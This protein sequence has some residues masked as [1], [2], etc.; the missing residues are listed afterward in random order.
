VKF[1]QQHEAVNYTDYILASNAIIPIGI[2]DG[3]RRYNICQ[4][5]EKPYPGKNRTKLRKDAEAEIQSFT[6]YLIS[7][8]AD[9]EVAQR[10][11]ANEAKNI[12]AEQ[13]L[14][15]S[16]EFCH[17]IRRGD[18]H[19]F[20]DFL[21]Q[22]PRTAPDEDGALQLYEQVLETIINKNDEGKLFVHG[23]VSAMY[24]YLAER[25]SSKSKFTM[26]LKK[27]GLEP[28]RLRRNGSEGQAAIA[29]T[30]NIDKD[31][32]S[33]WKAYINKKRPTGDRSARKA[34]LRV[35]K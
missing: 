34:K 2:D 31:A 5:Q 24:L 9:L 29:T 4:R 8:N 23:E 30:W 32:V 7:R 33:R 27:N 14:T 1:V 15:T 6:N 16:G 20:L 11:I 3:D 10:P 25:I 18:I 22:D 35:V 28:R 12:L 19:F 17:K 13:H 21:P 26:L